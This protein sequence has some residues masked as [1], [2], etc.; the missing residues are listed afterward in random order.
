MYK[1]CEMNDLLAPVSNSNWHSVPSNSL[2]NVYPCSEMGKDYSA[3]NLSFLVLSDLP[4]Y[5]VIK[6]DFLSNLV[7]FTISD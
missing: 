3:F 4:K 6:S 7:V 2:P 1:D 5:V